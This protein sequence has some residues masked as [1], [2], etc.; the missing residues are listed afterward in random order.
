MRN[1]EQKLYRP[2]SVRQKIY[3][4]VMN[5]KLATAYIG[6]INAVT[7][8][9]EGRRNGCVIAIPIISISDS[10]YQYDYNKC[11]LFRCSSE[12]NTHKTRTTRF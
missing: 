6:H 8:E 1:L 5:R 9:Q 12:E 3:R 7:C 2:A 4:N 11:L 10:R